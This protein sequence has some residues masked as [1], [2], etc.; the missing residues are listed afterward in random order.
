[1]AIAKLLKAS[2]G[3]VVKLKPAGPPALSPCGRPE[4]STLDPMAYGILGDT[5][6]CG[7][8]VNGVQAVSSA[9]WPTD[10]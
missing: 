3:N 10:G 4:P 8:A 5:E 1:V 9:I 6:H 2:G 7:Y